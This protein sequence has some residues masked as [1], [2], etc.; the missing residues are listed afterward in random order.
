M[1]SPELSPLGKPVGYDADYDP[2]LLFPIARAPE[3][4]T[5]T[6]SNGW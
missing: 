3:P 5:S 4:S 2:T 6:P 1:T